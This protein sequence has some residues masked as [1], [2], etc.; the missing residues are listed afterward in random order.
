MKQQKMSEAQMRQSIDYF[1][2]IAGRVAKGMDIGPRSWNGIVHG[3][4]CK[5][6][7]LKA[8][9]RKRRWGAGRL[10]RETVINPDEQGEAW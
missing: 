7:A 3:V 4:T 10:P 1:L 9:S 6:L 5:T 2:S 8:P